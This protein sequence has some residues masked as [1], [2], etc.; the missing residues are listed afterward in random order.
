MELQIKK[1]LRQGQ[2]LIG[3]RPQEKGDFVP[4]LLPTAYSPYRQFACEYHLQQGWETEGHFVPGVPGNFLFS[5]LLFRTLLSN[6][7]LFLPFHSL[8]LSSLLFCRCN[9]PSAWT[10]TVSR[11]CSSPHPFQLSGL[12]VTLNSSCPHWLCHSGL[13]PCLTKDLETTCRKMRYS[14]QAREITTEVAS[15][16]PWEGISCTR[17]HSPKKPSP[18]SP[19]V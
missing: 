15:R 7:H 1:Y 3:S 8:N 16:L 11:I 14:P 5:L 10:V 9:I 6:F 18:S 17:Q 19:P 13:I 2:V 12:Q 4:A